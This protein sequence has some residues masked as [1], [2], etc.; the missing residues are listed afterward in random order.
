MQ[1][2]TSRLMAQTR[3]SSP[4]RR[5]QRRIRRVA[6]DR[7]QVTAAGTEPLSYQWKENGADIGGATERTFVIP[8]LGYSDDDNYSV[9]H[10]QWRWHHKQRVSASPVLP[11]QRPTRHRGFGHAPA[12]S[13][14]ISPTPRGAGTTASR[15]TR[16][17]Q[18]QQCGG[19]RLYQTRRSAAV[20]YE[21][22]PSTPAGR[23]PSPPTRNTSRWASARFA[24]QDRG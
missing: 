17:L 14:E 23:P 24:I 18:Q 2:H 4:C 1:A 13:M 20:H 7:F 8:N 3:L 19:G 11:P 10:R 9:P 16:P 22:Q 12:V 6:R 5:R 15:F 21:T